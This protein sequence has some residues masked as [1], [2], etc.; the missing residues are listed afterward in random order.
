MYTK[1]AAIDIRSIILNTPILDL[2]QAFE[3]VFV[4]SP[5]NDYGFSLVMFSAMEE[6]IVAPLVNRVTQAE[7]WIAMKLFLSRANLDFRAKKN[8]NNNKKG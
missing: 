3:S 7:F 1:S 6:Y 2:W 8:Y 5:I 4:M